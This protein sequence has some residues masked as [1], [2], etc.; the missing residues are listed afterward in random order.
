MSPK[1][2]TPVRFLVVDDEELARQDVCILLRGIAGVEVLG[3]AADGEQALKILDG[4]G[5]DVVILDVTMPVLDGI[6]VMR[7][8]KGAGSPVRIVVLSGYAEFEYARAALAAGAVDYLLKPIQDEVFRRTIRAVAAAVRRDR[9]ERASG[10]ALWLDRCLEAMDRGGW[11][12]LDPCHAPEHHLGDLGFPHYVVLAVHDPD[13]DRDHGVSALLARFRT[14][15]VLYVAGPRHDGALTLAVAAAGEA[16]VL[17]AAFRRVE[18]RMRGTDARGAQ[19]RGGA[20]SIS[21][22]LS[23]V[24]S[25]PGGLPAACAEAREALKGRLTRGPGRLYRYTAPATAA[26][27]DT[28]AGTVRA[29]LERAAALLRSFRADPEAAVGGFRELV[30]G[31]FGRDV[32]EAAGLERLRLTFSEVVALVAEAF[33][34]VPEDGRALPA[35]LLSGDVLEELETADEIADFLCDLLRER[36]GDAMPRAVN[37]RELA[38]EARRLV[39]TRFF[40]PVSLAATARTLGLSAPYLSVLFKGRFGVNFLD[41]LTLTRTRQAKRLL[42]ETDLTVRQIA[43]EVGYTYPEYFQKVFRKRVGASPAEYRRAARP[44]AAPPS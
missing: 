21:C 5:V 39:D 43:A 42:K 17:E 15:P 38:E 6:G 14:V 37:G 44:G 31:V 8:L 2:A 23:S 29:G 20:A 34:A 41:Y 27:A 1:A 24:R 10:E 19:G 18:G 32:V 40:E 9:R 36:A 11:E 4:G 30:R 13:R 12:R 7:R 28:V 16:A 26:S 35:A 33:P 22:G 3:E 25:D